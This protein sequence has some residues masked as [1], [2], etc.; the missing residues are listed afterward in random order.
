MRRT[1]RRYRP[2]NH[3]QEQIVDAWC[4][5][6]I[7]WAAAARQVGCPMRKHDA[8]CNLQGVRGLLLATFVGVGIAAFAPEPKFPE[9]PTSLRGPGP[10]GQPSPEAQREFEEFDQASRAFRA[11]MA[12]Y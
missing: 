1:C 4:E 9:P 11:E 7:L 12:K 3:H 10:R 8:H 5:Q 6:V 2:P